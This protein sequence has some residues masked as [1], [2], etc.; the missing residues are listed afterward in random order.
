MDRVKDKV[1]IITGAARGIGKATA[2]MLAQEGASIAIVDMLAEEGK[3]TVKEIREKGFETR[4]TDSDREKDRNTTGSIY[5]KEA[6]AEYWKMNVTDEAQVKQVFNEIY[7]KFGRIDVLV[8]NAGIV[9]GDN[10]THKFP[11]E[12]WKKV[13]DVNVNGVFLCTKHVIPYMQKAGSGSII[14]MSSAYGIKGTPEVP[15]YHASKGTVRIMTKT[16]AVTYAPENIRVNSVHPGFVWTPMVEETAEQF[17]GV[18]M[19]RKNLAARHPIGFI[20]EPDDIAYGI[21]YLASNE[22]KFITGLE[23]V[24]DGGFIL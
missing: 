1:V 14:N 5:W 22:A 6:I 2:Q 21:L 24:I 7:D 16:D 10:P 11:L 15:A 8:N 12:E 20:A 9:C 17:G 3:Q 13:M 23:L 18:E 19:A 4:S